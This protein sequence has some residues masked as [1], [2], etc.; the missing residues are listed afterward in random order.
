MALKKIEYD[1]EETL[2]WYDPAKRM[3]LYQ[4]AAVL[5]VAALGYIVITNTHANMQKQSIVTGFSFLFDPASFD[6]SESL[7]SYSS[8]DSYLRA[9]TVGILNTLK[10]AVVG[11]ILA[12]S[13]GVIMGIAR[14]SSNW[15]VAKLAALYIEVMQNIPTL[16][17]LFFWYAVFYQNLPSPRKALT[18]LPGMFLCNRGLMVPVPETHYAHTYMLIALVIGLALAWGLN[19]WAKKRQAKTGQTFP[20]MPVGIAIT[21]GLPFLVW[22]VCGSPHGIDVPVLKGFNF[23]GG[24][25]ISPEFIALLLGLVLYTGAF[26]A[27]IV[28]AGIEATSKGQIEAAKALGF[29]RGRILRLIV[30]PQALR[31]IIPPLTSQMLNLTKNSSLAVGIGYPD[32]FALANTTINQTGQAVEGVAIIMVVYLFFSLTSSVFMNWYNKRSQLVER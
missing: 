6:I 3:I 7:I 2:F 27:E 25:N 1:S 21:M 30:L 8:A 9:F 11:T 16:L 26:V 22:L 24:V 19:R 23:R 18:P 32:F 10:V 4:A 28:R 13:L 12:I 14:L 5:L 20:V 15:L 31:I 17:Q 29:R